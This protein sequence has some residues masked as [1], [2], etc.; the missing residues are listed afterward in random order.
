MFAANMRLKLSPTEREERVDELIE[1][2]G[3]KLCQDT[4]I[5]NTFIKGVSGGE[6]KRTSIGLELITNPSIIFLD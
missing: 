2:L 5:G 6:R 1:E 4:K 3:L